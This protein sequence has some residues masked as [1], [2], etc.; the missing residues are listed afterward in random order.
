LKRQKL[1]TIDASKAVAYIRVSSDEQAEA[2]VSLDAQAAKLM[3]YGQVRG[4]ELVDVIS[5]P[6][7]SGHTPLGERAGGRRLLDLVEAGMVE[8]VLAV[9]LDRLF[10]NT[11]NCLQLVDIWS[12]QGVGLHILDMGGNAVDTSSAMGKMFLTMAAG[13]AEMERNLIAERTRAALERKRER[14]ERLGGHLPYGYEVLAGSKLLLESEADKKL[15]ARAKR[16]QR[17]GLSVRAIA[18]KLA[19][20][21]YVTRRGRPMTKSTVG[22]LLKGS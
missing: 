14:G 18:A 19:A 4:F 9:K 17:A 10:R 1:S 7:V 6:A 13:F 20:E 12:R 21:G 15:L 22:N 8:H 11:L 5:D 2:G 3:A 16:L